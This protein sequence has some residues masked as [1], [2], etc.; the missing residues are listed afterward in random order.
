MRSTLTLLSIIASS[1]HATTIYNDP[2]RTAYET[3]DSKTVNNLL[4]LNYG[5]TFEYIC[6]RG[7]I[8]MAAKFLQ[9]RTVSPETVSQTLLVL[10]DDHHLSMVK[11]LLTGPFSG[12][13]QPYEQ[14]PSVWATLM[15]IAC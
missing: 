3:G 2:L 11:F 7:D 8:E 1:L 6:E 13:F 5:N 15:P 12:R 9:S 10:A 14:S 4:S